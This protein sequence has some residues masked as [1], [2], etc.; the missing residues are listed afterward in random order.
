MFY[1]KKVRACVC[2]CGVCA[3]V[4][5]SVFLVPAFCVGHLSGAL[6]IYRVCFAAHF[7]PYTLAIK[8]LFH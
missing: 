3:R 1:V 6:I 7:L 8:Q 5:F 2:V 4:L